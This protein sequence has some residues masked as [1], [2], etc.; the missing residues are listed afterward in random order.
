M[1]DETNMKTKNTTKKQPQVILIIFVILMVLMI[2]SLFVLLYFITLNKLSA[3]GIFHVA[4]NI[5][6]ILEILVILICCK[7]YYQFNKKILTFFIFLLFGA[8]CC[9]ISAGLWLV[10]GRSILI[11]ERRIAYY[12]TYILSYLG[13][14]F[15]YLYISQSIPSN[16]TDKNT[17]KTIS[18]KSWLSQKQNLF[19]LILGLIGLSICLFTDKIFI[20]S[21]TGEYVN[22]SLAFVPAALNIFII[23]LLC[24]T[25]F[26]LKNFK[27]YYLSI[28][29]FIII[30]LIIVV[31]HLI[32]LYY[33]PTFFLI[34]SSAL[35]TY[36]VSYR[37]MEKESQKLSNQITHIASN[38]DT[39]ENHMVK[40]KNITILQCRIRDFDSYVKLNEPE[41]I[42]TILNHFFSE[43]VKII[44]DNNGIVLDYDNYGV[45]ALFGSKGNGRFVPSSIKTAFTITK[46]MKQI[47]EWNSGHNYPELSIS[48]ALCTGKAV[49]GNIGTINHMRYSALTRMID[50]SG[51][52]LKLTNENEIIIN[53]DT[54][55][56]AGMVLNTM[57]RQVVRLVGFEDPIFY[58]KIYEEVK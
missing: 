30:N 22:G 19:I 56:A 44:E 27:S 36:V 18:L 53:E 40:K 23:I 48:T 39:D 14:I 47:N 24:F 10:N 52:L 9:F 34:T 1:K 43:L 35:I 41:K 25:T 45:V 13:N 7:E 5:F 12:F 55:N 11:P 42:Y 50:L 2:L 38:L 3:I 46:K 20:L 33:E 29:P 31:W 49:I 8:F 54:Q 32:S 17:E 21:D 37:E 15:Y 58:Y 6:A 57:G 16:N 4:V 28:I 26:K 51:L